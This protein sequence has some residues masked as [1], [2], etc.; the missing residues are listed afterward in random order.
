MLRLLATTP[1]IPLQIWA[2][3]HRA[4]EVVAGSHDTFVLRAKLQVRVEVAWDPTLPPAGS[5]PVVEL[6]SLEPSSVTTKQRRSVVRFRPKSGDSSQRSEWLQADRQE[7][8]FALPATG[9]YAVNA[10]FSP[11]RPAKKAK[12]RLAASGGTIQVN[13]ASDAQIFRVELTMVDVAARERR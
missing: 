7:F 10:H 3:D 13:E 5:R 6:E 2:N 12:A 4:L 8:V 9:L 1:A 11:T